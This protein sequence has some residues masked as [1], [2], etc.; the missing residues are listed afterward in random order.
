MRKL[1]GDLSVSPE[2]NDHRLYPIGFHRALDPQPNVCFV[3]RGIIGDDQCAIAAYVD[4]SRWVLRQPPGTAISRRDRF[5]TAWHLY[6]ALRRELE[7]YAGTLRV[8][9]SDVNCAHGFI[10]LDHRTRSSDHVVA[11]NSQWSATDRPGCSCGSRARSFRRY[12]RR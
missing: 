1:E 4:Y 7:T 12:A 11:L 10:L 5:F 2:A 6:E 8:L 9:N 3:G